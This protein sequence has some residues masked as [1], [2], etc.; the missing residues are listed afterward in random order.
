M[1]KTTY[2]YNRDSRPIDR[3]SYLER[4]LSYSCKWTLEQKIL[5][6]PELDQRSRAGRQR[7]ELLSI[8]E[9]AHE[10][11]GHIGLMSGVLDGLDLSYWL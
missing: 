1:A 5:P 9:W 6:A 3:Y 10:I 7:P 8:Q 4:V 2:F 11:P